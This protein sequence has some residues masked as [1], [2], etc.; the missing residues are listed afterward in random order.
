[1]KRMNELQQELIDL[2]GLAGHHCKYLVFCAPSHSCVDCKDNTQV[3]LP[4]A[5]LLDVAEVKM[6]NAEVTPTLEGLREG[7]KIV[8]H[9]FG[10]LD[11]LEDDIPSSDRCDT[12][13]EARL[14]CVVE[15]MKWIKKREE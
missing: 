9:A 3:P 14:Q 12:R 5:E 15:A 13:F 8:W 4:L 1:M 11:G 10:V 6:I 2:L 7:G